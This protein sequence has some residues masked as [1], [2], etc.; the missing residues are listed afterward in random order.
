[1]QPLQPETIERLRAVST[2]TLTTQLF[3]RGFRNVFMQGVRALRPSTR[4]M[5]GPASTLRNI[6][7]R[8]DLDH[9]G[10]FADPGHPQRRSIETAKEGHI[11]VVDCRG[12]ARVASAGQ[13][14]VTRLHVRGAA[15]LV[16]DGGVRDSGPISEMDFPVFCA[17]PSAPL[18]LVL[19]HAVDIDVPIAC[20]GVPVYPGDVVVGDRDGVVVIPRALADEVATDAAAQE[21]MEEFILERIAGGA[22]LPGTYPP[23]DETRAA[24]EVWRS[25]RR[26]TAIA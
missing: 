23:S 3:K 13:I 20:G 22:P 17:C 18:N 2:A 19:H 11:L 15:G 26:K 7:A 9:L 10:V 21:E 12:D 25:S 14:L 4:T 24:Y 1:M 6:P 8:E 16:S 5:V